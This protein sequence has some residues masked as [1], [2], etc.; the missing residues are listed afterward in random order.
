[1]YA[2]RSGWWEWLGGS[3]I[4]FWRWPSRYKD[5]ALQGVPPYFIADPPTT[6]EKQ[7]AYT[8]EANRLLVKEKVEEV[9]NKGYIVRT[10]PTGVRSL[11]FMFDVPKGLDDVRMVYNGSRSGLNDALWAPWFSLPTVETMTRALLP[12]YWCAD[13]DYG[14]QFLN[15]NLHKDLQPYCGVDLSQLLPEEVCEHTGLILGAWSRNAMG[16][17]PSPYGSVKGA[18]R[19]K[20]VI[21]GERR[22]KQ[23]PFHW[24]KVCTN[25][26]GSECYVATMPSIQ[27]RRYDG[28]L[29][30]ELIQYI[31]NLRTTAKDRWLAWS[32]SSRIA[33]MCCWLGLQD[34]ARKRREPSQ[35]PGAW[36]GATVCTDWNNAYKSVTDDQWMKTKKRIRWLAFQAGLTAAA[37]DLD[38]LLDLKELGLE[39]REAPEGCMLHKTAGSYWGFL[40]YVSRTYH[41]MVPY[42]KGIHLSLDR[43]RE[44][45]NED[46]WR[47]ANVYEVKLEYEGRKKPPKWT[48]MVPRFKNNMMAL[49]HMTDAALPPAVPVRPTNTAAVFMVGDASGSGFGT[50]TWTQNAEELTAQFGAWDLETSRESSNFREAYNLVLRVEQM[51]EKGELQEGSEL[52]VFTDNF[53]SERVFH[54]GS[55]KSKRLHA[56]VMRLRKLEMEGKVVVHVIW[57]AGTRMK[58]QGTDGL[59]RG[60]LT[61]GVMVGDRFLTH[62]PLNKTV[63][64]RAVEFKAEFEKGFPGNSWKWLD[65]DGWFE[66]A[67]ENDHGCYVWT[68][69]PALADVAMEQMCEVKHVHP[70]TSHVFLCPALMTAR[71]RKQ[72]LKASDVCLSLLQGSPA[73]VDKQHELVVCALIGP[74]LSCRPWKV[75]SHHWVEEWRSEVP[76]MWRQGGSAWRGHMR[77]FWLGAHSRTG[78]L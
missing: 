36:A 52:F 1:V 21:L 51:V 28:H 31:D 67:F 48:P 5:E 26:P 55:S 18:L 45:R 33:K 40:V 30:T 66:E 75:K 53:V 37:A 39:R 65:Y 42:L 43:W 68:L 60:D 59:S 44:N 54:N 27:K 19:A 17:K 16:L 8:D 32:A 14:E 47:I 78:N 73:W 72:L 22:D 57:C 29:A 13:N 69:P 2:R 25:M 38:K 4:F 41:A 56:L 12:G 74:L 24:E 15:F 62:I 63:L 64:D 20:R 10:S 9:L 3:H 23:N 77:K 7:P 71:W 35:S 50:S 70:Y 61:G 58:D 6:M 34:A 11:M 46:G 49:M 76:R